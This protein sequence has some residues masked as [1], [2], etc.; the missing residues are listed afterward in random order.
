MSDASPDPDAKVFA[1]ECSLLAMH[2]EKVKDVDEERLLGLL[3]L[4]IYVIYSSVASA[5]FDQENQWNPSAEI[6]KISKINSQQ[7]AFPSLANFIAAV[8]KAH[9]MTECFRVTFDQVINFLEQLIQ[10]DR[11]FNASQNQSIF[12]EVLYEVVGKA[13]SRRGPQ[14]FIQHNTPKSKIINAIKNVNGHEDEIRSSMTN[15]GALGVDQITKDIWRE[16]NFT[17]TLEVQTSTSQALITTSCEKSWQLPTPSLVDRACMMNLGK[18]SKQGDGNMFI[19]V[20]LRTA[21][22][23][24]SS[25][26]N[27]T[28]FS[29]T[30]ECDLPRNLSLLPKTDLYCSLDG[31]PPIETHLFKL[32]YCNKKNERVK[33]L[34]NLALILYPH[35]PLDISRRAAWDFAER[36]SCT[37]PKCPA[38]FTNPDD[39]IYGIGL[40]LMKASAGLNLARCEPFSWKL[41][42]RQFLLNPRLRIELPVIYSFLRLNDRFDLVDHLADKDFVS[43]VRHLFQGRSLLPKEAQKFCPLFKEYLGGDISRTDLTVNNQ[44]VLNLLLSLSSAHN[45]FITT[46]SDHSHVK[47]VD[48]ADYKLPTMLN[49]VRLSAEDIGSELVRAIGDSVGDDGVPVLQRKHEERF[50]SALSSGT[51]YVIIHESVRPKMYQKHESCIHQFKEKFGSKKLTREQ[52]QALYDE[53]MD[54]DRTGLVM[55]L[56][57]VVYHILSRSISHDESLKAF[58]EKTP[59]IGMK[60]MSGMESR[61][62]VDGFVNANAKAG[63]DFTL[64]QIPEIHRALLSADVPPTP[65]ELSWL[66]SLRDNE[67]HLLKQGIIRFMLYSEFHRQDVSVEEFEHSLFRE[68][69]SDEENSVFEAITK[70]ILAATGIK[71]LN[72]LLQHINKRIRSCQ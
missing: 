38:I 68:S 37:I 55:F 61:A 46:L 31:L 14:S 52:R 19:P 56:E 21:D 65:P 70:P 39:M 18:K 62:Y 48:V 63:V 28:G 17:G 22:V 15:A 66:L 7:K 54:V 3:A 53:V 9:L 27:F 26:E 30:I 20:Y 57:R 47:V 59:E 34:D 72:D 41:L 50:I 4:E 32:F 43:G 8:H 23:V 24:C 67:I 35:T 64:R 5:A 29:C 45:E 60:T 36:I 51:Y 11:E 12:S 58:V 16:M 42:L 1:G 13:I 71:E 10:A 69:M 25:F 44:E 6:Q 33:A 49:A 2:I 40:F